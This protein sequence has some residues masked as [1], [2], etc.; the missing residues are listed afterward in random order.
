MMPRTLPA[1]AVGARIEGVALTQALSKE[2]VAEFARAF[3][4]ARFIILRIG[5]PKGKATETPEKPAA[6]GGKSKAKVIEEYEFVSIGHFRQEHA[7]QHVLTVT[8]EDPETLEA[9]ERILANLP[10]DDGGAG[11]G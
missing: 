10:V 7:D 11:G 1:R 9:I 6:P 3:P 4:G 8:C 2:F 5:V